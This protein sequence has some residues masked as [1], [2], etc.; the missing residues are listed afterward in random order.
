MRPYTYSHNDTVANYSHYNQPLAHPLGANFLELIGILRY[1][2]AYRWNIEVKCIYYKQ[3]LDSA[4]ENFG[5]NILLNY[6]TR[7]REYGFYIYSG[8]PATVVNATAYLSYQVEGKFIS[9]RHHHA[10]H[11]HRA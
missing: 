11:I 2:P 1:Q 3:G 6:N 10:S 5:S 9:G 7:P 4:G 8:V